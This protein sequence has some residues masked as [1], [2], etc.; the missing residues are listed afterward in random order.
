MDG[1]RKACYNAAMKRIW[2]IL[3]CIG[4]LLLLGCEKEPET[5]VIG[6]TAITPDAAGESLQ[7]Q[8]DG[9][10]GKAQAQVRDTVAYVLPCLE[11]PSLYGAAAYENTGDTPLYITQAEF[12]FSLPGLREEIQF[13][14]VFSQETVVLPGETSYVALW[15]AY[16]DLTPGTEV[17][18]DATLHWEA[19]EGERVALSADSIH[20]A[21]NYPAFVSMAGTVTAQQDCPCNLVYTAFYDEADQLL[22][23]WYFTVNAQLFAGEPYS[24]TTHMKEL[25]LPELEDQ[26]AR[27]ESFGVGIQ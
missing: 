15:Y 25:P 7:P 18:L 9:A 14:P 2:I 23:V 1:W 22:G 3:I 4:L 20:L 13:T 5:V 16:P 11:G 6:M 27:V 17:T 24:F 26:A 10:G 21:R 8:A 19:T 12:T